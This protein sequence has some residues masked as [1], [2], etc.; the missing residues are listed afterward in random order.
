ML[1]I[2]AYFIAHILIHMLQSDSEVMDKVVQDASLRETYIFQLLLLHII[3]DF[4]LSKSTFKLRNDLYSM[5]LDT[6]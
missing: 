2:P 5:Q 4:T 1:F 6:L 3:Q